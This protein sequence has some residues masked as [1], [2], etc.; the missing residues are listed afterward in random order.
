MVFGNLFNQR[1]ELVM[2]LT[3]VCMWSGHGW[4]RITAPEA[5]RKF[6]C[7]ISASS[8]LFMCDI[9]GQYVTLASGSIRDPYFKHSS[10]EKSKDCPERTLG[11]NY[12]YGFNEQAHDLPIRLRV[13][14]NNSF[15][16]SL[17]FMALPP[18]IIGKRDGRKISIQGRGRN[19][20]VQYSLERLN[21]YSITYLS[22]GDEPCD[23]YSI[24]YPSDL[25]KINNFWP[26]T[27]QG[28]SYDGT[29]FDKDTGK[30]LPEDADVS[31][32]QIYYLLTRRS[33][34]H[35]N[36]GIN[37]RRICQKSGSYFMRWYVYEVQAVRYDED[38]ARFFLE[39]HARLTDHPVTFFPV[40]PEFI[41]YPYKVLHQSDEMYFYLEGEGVE[42]K[43]Y[44]YAPVRS[45]KTNNETVS[46]QQIK[47]NDWQQLVS[48]GRVKV[49]KYTYLWK[50]KLEFP[51]KEKKLF[52]ISDGDQQ[53]VESGLSEELPKDGVLYVQCEVDG[54]AE[55]KDSDGFVLMRYSLPTGV[56]IAIENIHYNSSVDVYCGLDI[57]WAARFI[58]PQNNT[59][60][61]VFLIQRLRSFNNDYIVI[62]HAIGGIAAKLS[63]RPRLKQW[64]S[65]QVRSGRISRKAL[66]L[67]R[68]EVRGKH[69]SKN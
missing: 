25:T 32:G 1:E 29:L 10:E 35:N 66:N 53:E 15:E 3:H 22:L 21:P 69:G 45:W 58:R 31:V 51:L 8:G 14:S 24:G 64:I 20:C 34:M 61:D 65:S 19:F 41:E 55:I 56:R 52:S 18:S 26:T 47:C 43:A 11:S 12:S 48:A 50:N 17:G 42:P 39:L 28:I 37:L 60:D 44:P 49:L 38:S 13:K 23:S 54:F 68:E 36:S 33:W 59:K 9:C 46:I 16:L 57:V 2:P 27:V 63:G 4:K 40:W 5:A 7:G 62:P 6:P 30:K 67:L